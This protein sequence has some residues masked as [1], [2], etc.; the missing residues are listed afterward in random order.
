MNGNSIKHGDRTSR[1]IDT[2]RQNLS[3]RLDT[4]KETELVALSLFAR[5][6][7]TRRLLEVETIEVHHL[8]P[9]LGEILNE[10]RF[11]VCGCV[12]F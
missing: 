2:F 1:D 12:D 9:G 10:L 5:C 6:D 11:A 7:W 4:E 8:G 3:L